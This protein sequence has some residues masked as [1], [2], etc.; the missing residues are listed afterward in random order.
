MS[1]LS[2]RNIVP[3]LQG[4]GIFAYIFTFFWGC[5]GMG[6]RKLGFNTP[7]SVCGGTCDSEEKK[8]IEEGEKT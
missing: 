6:E 5:K 2:H 4:V 1:T 3:Y 7:S 8:N